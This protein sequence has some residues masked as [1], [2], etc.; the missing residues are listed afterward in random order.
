MAKAPRSE[1]GSVQAEVQPPLTPP[2]RKTSFC[3][4][5]LR[6][7]LCCGS[8]SRSRKLDNSPGQARVGARRSLAHGGLREAAATALTY[9]GQGH[10]TPCPYL[11][12]KGC[13]ASGSLGISPLGFLRVGSS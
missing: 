8:P 12:K 1:Q 13:L 3:P 2:A 9:P 7:D 10:G 4:Q 5:K 6:C 11:S